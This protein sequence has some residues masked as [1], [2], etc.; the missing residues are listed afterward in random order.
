MAIVR[1]HRRIAAARVAAIARRL[2]DASELC[3]I[4]TVAPRGR[5]HV[6]TAYFAWSPQFEIVWLSE[7]RAGHSRNIRSNGTV[8]IAVYDSRQSWGRPDRGM[9]LFGSAVE[10]AAADAVRAEKL[11]AKR[12]PA[13]TDAD[14]SAYR[15]YLFTPRRL[16]LFDEHALAAGTFVTARV[17]R[18]ARLAWE[19]TEI[20]RSS[21]RSG[22]S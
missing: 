18:E 20:Y 5:A 16:K 13:F 17:D 12:F 22:K 15:Y 4:A 3:A 1:S 11:Y 7:P 10:A 9:Q 2:L 8:A 14:L 21:S 19:R 6:S